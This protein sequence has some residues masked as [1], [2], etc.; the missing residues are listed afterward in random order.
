[1]DYNLNSSLSDFFD[2]NNPANQR[3]Y[4]LQDKDGIGTRVKKAF[5]EE[6]VHQFR[7]KLFLNSIEHISKDD[8]LKLDH[9]IDCLQTHNILPYAP[10]SYKEIID[11][12]TKETDKNKLE[13]KLKCY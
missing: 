13:D 6:F 12:N 4:N 2:S 1:M 3:L 8:A 9:T 10:N 11:K 5:E 7:N